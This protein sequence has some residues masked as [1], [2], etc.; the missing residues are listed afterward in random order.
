MA[1]ITLVAQPG[2]AT[3]SSSSRRLR[4]E[5]RVPGIVYG[6]VTEPVAVSVDARELRH[7]LSGAAGVNQL[8]SIDV[9]GTSHLAMARSLQRHP[10][11]GTVVHVDF[12]V[13][14]RDEIVSADVPVTLVGEAKEVEQAK[15]VVEQLLTS[16]TIHARPGSIPNAIEIDV[17]GLAVGETIRVGQLPLPA[18]VTTDVDPEEPVVLAAVS[19]VAA[20]VAEIE[21][22]EADVAETADASGAESG[23]DGGES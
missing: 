13:V 18:G 17:T 1:E 21:A 12:Q 7:A 11:R 8:L 22:S 10:V 23:A 14:S 9:A 3:G 4:A 5:G 2:R 15:G 6:R 19:E 20:E 16:L